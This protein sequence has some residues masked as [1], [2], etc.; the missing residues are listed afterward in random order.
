MLNIFFRNVS[1][2]ICK[3]KF[4]EV[5]SAS[6]NFILS[7]LRNLTR[8]VPLSLESGNVILLED[9]HMPEMDESCIRWRKVYNKR[10]NVSASQ[11]CGGMD[12]IL[13]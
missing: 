11:P 12:A 9:I 5:S 13:T 1:S 6:N 10:G 7:V 3:D 2:G 8:R 4:Q